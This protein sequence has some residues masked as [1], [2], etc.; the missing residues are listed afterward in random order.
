MTDFTKRISPIY[1]NI[2]D[3]TNVSNIT[4]T[5]YEKEYPYLINLINIL[6][7]EVYN[8]HTHVLKLQSELEELKFLIE[9]FTG[10]DKNDSI[11][12]YN[13]TF[14]HAY[15]I[16]EE[17]NRYLEQISSPY[18]GRVT[19]DR[20]ANENFPKGKITSYIGK[21]AYFDK[22]TKRPLVT[23]WRAP[24]ANLYYMNA[25]PC[26]DVQFE[27][28]VG[29]QTGDL[30]EKTQFDIAGGRITNVY[31]TQTGNSTAD[32]FLL[33]QLTKKIGKKL[34]DIV[35][36]IQDLQN[37]IIREN[38]DGPMII[39][40]V[41]GSGKTTILLHRIAYLLYGFQKEIAAE[42]S[43]IIA[44]SKMFLDYISEIL[45]SLGVD[46]IMRNT[47]LSWA[48]SILS[49]DDSYVL[50][51]EKDNL[52]VKTFKG[53]E[54]FIVLINQFIEDFEEDLFNKIKD[55]L[56]DKIAARYYELGKLHP[57][58]SMFE[59]MN[60]AVEYAFAQQQFIFKTTGNFM[61]N[62]DTQNVRQKA[63]LDYIKKR[64]DIFRLYK[65]MF[66]FEYLFKKSGIDPKIASILRDFSI[67]TLETSG[68]LKYYKTEDLAPLVW[69][70][71][72]LFGIGDNRRDYIAIDEAQDMSLFQL[73]T[74]HMIAKNGNITIAGDLAQSI[75]EP[76][77]LSDWNELIDLY[78]KYFGT[79][80]KYH[81]LD[82][83]YRTTVEVI[84]YA[85]KVIEGKF[86]SSYKLP[87]AVLRHGDPVKTV[88]LESEIA[89]EVQ[90]Q[91]DIEKVVKIITEED[92][93]GFATLALVC[94]DTKHADKVFTNIK[95]FA[96]KLPRNIFNYSEEDYHE[97]ILVL[98]VER[99][100]GLE[101]DSV[102]VVDMNE[103]N[104]PKSFLNAKL[105]YVAVTRALHRL[106]VITNKDC[107]SSSLIN[108]HNS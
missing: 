38:I 55:P 82:K 31:N 28:P 71:F 29:I 84:E 61:G 36:T 106:H 7:E 12:D 56:K 63:I 25:G 17:L 72:K 39:Q 32:A 99:A 13:E 33:T 87:E 105:F 67:K 26:K 58:L 9:S 60:L 30:S 101:F 108:S 98:P 65:E 80:T 50:S 18:F 76:F 93:K 97:G 41:A 8:K 16:V 15:R 107:K 89:S 90:V 24:I 95:K 62:L 35:S 20:N 43:L 88:E 45:P 21:F 6:G 96:N 3:I 104:Y 51:P 92:K 34:T 23:D 27:S 69:M 100:K 54:N 14:K 73:L 57:T 11:K 22:E 78:K 91:S 83:C 66:K 102:I 49:W 81:H 4:D 40:G 10:D 1:R 85:N 103:K 42:N 68:K 64:T 48:K 37:K 86:P 75:I 59:K 44:P 5:T 70:H 52:D 79:E 94:R 77:Y 19:F 53:T 46:Q 74:L 2:D 47:Y